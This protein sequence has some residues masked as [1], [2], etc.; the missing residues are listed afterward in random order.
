VWQQH[1]I[2]PPRIRQ[3]WRFR[4]PSCAPL[5]ALDHEKSD[6]TSFRKIQVCSRSMVSKL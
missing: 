1:Q 6:T 5:K 3:S 2:Y 4:K